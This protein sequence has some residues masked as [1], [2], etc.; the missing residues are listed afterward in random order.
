M[1]TVLN[2]FKTVASVLTTSSVELYT[3]TVGYT[4]IVLL[5]QISNVTSSASTATV[6]YYDG[7]NYRSLLQAF[8]IPGNDST[9][10]VS[11]KLVVPEGKSIWALAG[12]N[13]TMHI[14]L[15]ILETFNG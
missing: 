9:S 12:A 7:T 5:A 2:Q 15:S 4:G 3:P 11:G 1:A 14:T 13:S 10:A 6:S 8:S